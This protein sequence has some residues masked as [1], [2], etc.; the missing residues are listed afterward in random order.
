[1]TAFFL[2]AVPDYY[3]NFKTK[4]LIT[5]VDIS[6]AIQRLS[7]GIHA[8]FPTSTWPTVMRNILLE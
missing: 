7:R 8:A 5:N 6:F 2:H 4:Q 1:M 3:C